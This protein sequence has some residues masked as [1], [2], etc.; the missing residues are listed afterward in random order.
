MA[1]TRCHRAPAADHPLQKSV[2]GT[3]L[4]TVRH[5]VASGMGIT[6]LPCT[7]AGSDRMVGVYWR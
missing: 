5:M 6:V 7:A 1:H 4:E 3:S 2:E